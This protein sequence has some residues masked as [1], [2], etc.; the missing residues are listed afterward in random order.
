GGVQPPMVVSPD[1]RKVAVVIDAFPDCTDDDC[2]K[3]MR[4]AEEKDPVKAH[5]ITALPYR[6]WDEWRTNVRA[7]IVIVDIETG[8]ARDVT[9]GDYDSPTHF[10][11]DNG[12]AFSPN[13]STLA[14]VSNRDGKDKE[15]MST[16]R[17][18]WLVSTSGGEAKR[19]TSNS[20][21]DEQP[22]FS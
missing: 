22:V 14:F 9:P 2:N 19:L 16:N 6:H 11:E 18:V 5:V 4:E 21:A 3:R 10:Y 17:D 8:E 7:H 1:S 20:A 13:G 12:I 15:M